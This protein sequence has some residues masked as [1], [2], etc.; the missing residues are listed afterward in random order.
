LLIVAVGAL[1]WAFV[2]AVPDDLPDYSLNSAVV[3]RVERALVLCAAFAL[4]GVF[5]TRLMV[6]DLPSGITARGIEWKGEE[7]IVATLEQTKGLVKTLREANE[8]TAKAI[9]LLSQRSDALPPQVAA[10]RDASERNGRAIELITDSLKAFEALP[11]ELVALQTEV[12]ELSSK[13]ARLVD[14]VDTLKDK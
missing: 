3:F 12:S 5:T 6:G 8:G 14:R 11:S 7:Q 9:Q 4:I 2:A 13:L 1:V 10:I